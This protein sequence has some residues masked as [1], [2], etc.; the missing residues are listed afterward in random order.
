[1]NETILAD[2]LGGKKKKRVVNSHSHLGL[3]FALIRA[4]PQPIDAMSQ[5][6]DPSSLRSRP[7]H[8]HPW[9]R[10]RRRVLTGVLNTMEMKMKN[11]GK[12]TIYRHQP[13]EDSGFQNHP[14]VCRANR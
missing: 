9:Q 11:R 12:S 7:R 10:M 3:L 13:K 2:R 8:G 14:R 1:M 4:P 5:I 6:P